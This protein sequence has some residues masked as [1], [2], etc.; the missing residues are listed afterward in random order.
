MLSE[1][2]STDA[3]ITN[4]LGNIAMGSSKADMDL[5]YRMFLPKFVPLY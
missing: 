2:D 3:L 1:M 5:A 4:Y